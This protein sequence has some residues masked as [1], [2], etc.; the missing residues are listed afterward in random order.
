MT[1]PLKEKLNK[2]SSKHNI[3]SKRMNHNG[4]IS[5][6]CPMKSAFHS[7]IILLC[8]L[9]ECWVNIK[10]GNADCNIVTGIESDMISLSQKGSLFETRYITERCLE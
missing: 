6:L 9:V 4:I 5:M 3:H 10:N 1:R 8:R 2:Q 7:G